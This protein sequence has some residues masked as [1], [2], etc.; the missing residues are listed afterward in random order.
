MRVSGFSKAFLW[1]AAAVFASAGSLAFLFFLDGFCAREKAVEIPRGLGLFEIARKLESEGVVR[2]AEIF[3]LLV[4]LGGDQSRL[5]SGEY[6]FS[7]GATPDLV[8]RKLVG[9]ERMLRKVTFPEGVALSRM[10]EILETSAI[11]SREEFLGLASDGGYASKKLGI[12]V[13]SL[14]G[15][16]FPDTYF[17]E[18]DA[19]AEKAIETML[20]RFRK[21]YSTLRAT[22]SD[23]GMK[24]IV[25]VASMIEKESSIPGERPLISAVI[26]N[27]LRRGMR[28]EFD[29]TVIYALGER[30]TGDLTRKDLDFSSPYNTYVFAGLPPGPIAAPGLDSLEAALNPADA[31]YLYFVSRGDGSHFFSRRYRDHV[32]AVNRMIRKK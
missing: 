3:S 6:G 17:F 29:P 1:L 21:A 2:K 10:A 14:E 4:I 12:D 28:L 8:R 25:T 27:R 26:R 30:F 22:D 23:L 9:G 19:G 11:A 20:S 32:N 15:F 5:R 18:K 13:P 16:L 24:E 31:D 7:P